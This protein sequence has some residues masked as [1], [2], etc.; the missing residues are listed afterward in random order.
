[1]K[2]K[3]IIPII[4][5]L[6]LAL[7]GCGKNV[8]RPLNITGTATPDGQFVIDYEAF[9]PLPTPPVVEY[10]VTKDAE[11]VNNFVFTVL[12]KAD[13]ETPKAGIFRAEVEMLDDR[14]F[15]AS[16][17]LEDSDYPANF[18]PSRGIQISKPAL[19]K[20]TEEEQ[21]PEAEIQE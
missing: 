21:I 10:T 5:F 2:T 12:K 20:P 19:V 13:S 18:F 11:G 7:V 8:V 4:S 9:K 14:R 17:A 15:R 1:M 16:I 6:L 3:T